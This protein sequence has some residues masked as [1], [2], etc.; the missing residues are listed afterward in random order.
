[1]Y[2]HFD[3]RLNLLSVHRSTIRMCAVLKKRI[4]VIAKQKL[5]MSQKGPAI[6]EKANP[7]QYV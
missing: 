3:G 5:S 2:L 4:W 7:Y 6:A 1:M